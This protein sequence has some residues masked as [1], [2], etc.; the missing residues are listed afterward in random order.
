ML[1]SVLYLKFGRETN[2]NKLLGDRKFYKNVL[3]L[4]LPIM[5]QNGITNF[6][7]MLDNVMVG[8]V[9]TI[10]MTGVA[11]TN[12]LIF[13]LNL[14]IFGAI[15]G[16][17][18]FGAQFFGKNDHKGVRDT[19]RFKIILCTLLTALGIAIFLLFGDDLI[20]L[21]LKGDSGTADAAEALKYAHE[22]LA[23]MLI[24]FFP[25]TLAQC[26]SST[27]R[28]VGRPVP[29]MVAGVIAVCINLLL[30]TI[31]IFGFLGAPA[32]GVAGA[33]IATVISRFAELFIIA[34]W[35]HKNS[36]ELPFIK[37][38]FKSLA[39]PRELVRSI[40]IKGLPLMAN[41]T[42][43]AAG[44]AMVNQCYSVRG[45]DVVAANNISQTFF[46]VFSVAFMAVGVSIGII[47]GQKL[48]AGDC[49]GAR[50]DSIRLRSFSVFIS[51]VVALVFAVCSL[52]I[53]KIYNT[54]DEVRSIATGLMLIC[55][56]CMP[57]DAFAHA[58]Y[59][60]LRS[61]GKTLVTMLFDSC[62]VWVV[63]VPA[64]FL[65]SRFTD[66]PIIPLYAI[67]QSLNLVKCIVGYFLVKSGIWVKNIVSE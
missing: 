65:L 26:Y 15:S 62:F 39:I 1:K 37:G 31:L 22:Y 16:A 6:V 30:N 12:Q 34:V 46:N 11:V 27:L 18:I 9:G 38:A 5:I 45:I 67:C 42:I 50:A 2:L 19:F 10:Q 53:P 56:A 14:C 54:N 58:S 52:F 7:N 41:E 20:M 29:P 61:G 3:A 28:E 35:T 13:V 21:Y 64:A 55:A 48:G 47:L 8:R 24:G 36:A 44:I 33:A 57:I 59:F 4:A 25:Y 60:T 63:S 23:I 32:L 49:E 66:I 43:W 40:T 51:V 17:G